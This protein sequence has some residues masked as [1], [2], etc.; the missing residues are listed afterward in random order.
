MKAPASHPQRTESGAATNPAAAE[1]QLLRSKLLAAGQEAETIKARLRDAELELQSAHVHLNDKPSRNYTKQV[2][3]EESARYE[4][5][6]E[7]DLMQL[8]LSHSP[9][10]I[11]VLQGPDLHVTWLN[12]ASAEAIGSGP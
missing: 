1:I 10:L 2:T 6:R 9:V 5:E 7:R 4:A 12:D 11:G 8:V 3:S